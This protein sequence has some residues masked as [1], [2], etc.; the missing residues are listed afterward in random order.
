MSLIYRDISLVANQPQT[1]A[2]IIGVGDYPHLRNG[3]AFRERPATSTMGLGQL[4]SSPISAKAFSDWMV[5][6]FNNPNAPLGTVE[7]LLSLVNRASKQIMEALFPSNQPQW[8][9]SKMHS[10]VGMSVAIHLKKTLLF[11]ISVGMG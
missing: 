9:I 5:N 11:S 1:H 3:S 2:I 4:T 8:I 7:L 6:N 10:T